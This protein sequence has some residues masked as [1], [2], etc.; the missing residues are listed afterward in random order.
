MMRLTTG[1]AILALA[2][3]AGADRAAARD[4]APVA[5]QADSRRGEPPS[6]WTPT[7]EQVAEL[8]RQ[9][10]MPGGQ[11]LQRFSRL[12]RGVTFG[13]RRFIRGRYESPGD[14]YLILTPEDGFPLVSV[15]AFATD[16]A[17]YGIYY[18]VDRRQLVGP[19]RW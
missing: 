13:G 10:R 9:V 14:G 18:D 11:S 4:E 12:Y 8:E 3:G 7:E 5:A 2:L 6:S 15:G 17:T 19:A 16:T 1:M